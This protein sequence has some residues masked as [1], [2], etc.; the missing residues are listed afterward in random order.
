M[1]E[2]NREEIA[3][4]E[5]LYANNPGG[6][7]F[8]H[9]A[10]AY[11]KA[12]ELDRAR[13]ILEDGITRH[14]EYASA[15]VVLGR[16]LQD[17]GARDEA[18]A[19]FRRV[20]EL[21]PENRVALRSLGDLARDGNQ[22]EEALSYFRQL[23]SLDPTDDQI[24]RT[25][26][27]L[28]AA[29]HAGQTAP[30]G[31]P[32]TKPA[33]DAGAQNAP[34]TPVPA[35]EA[36]APEPRA[37]VT[38][39]PEFAEASAGAVSTRTEELP[40]AGDSAGPAT[41]MPDFA[42]ITPESAIQSVVP[43]A[44]VPTE[45]GD[46]SEFVTP[47]IRLDWDNAE[48]SPA[49]TAPLPGDLAAFVEAANVDAGADAA[50]EAWVPEAG[51]W[52]GEAASEAGSAGDG[53][54][55]QDREPT[56]EELLSSSRGSGRPLA[57]EPER[58]VPQVELQT[59]TLA[60][61]YLSQGFNDRAAEVY[62]SL[63]E[64]NPGD[65]RL[66]RRLAEV[67][68]KLAAAGST[69]AAEDADA[70]DPFWAGGAEAATPEAM[71]YGWEP[72]A[73]EPAGPTIGAYF[74]QLLSWRPSAGHGSVTS[75]AEGAPAAVKAVPEPVAAES[76]ASTFAEA[77]PLPKEGGEPATAFDEM[78]T[79][80]SG[81]GVSAFEEVEAPKDRDALVAQEPA[82]AP[83]TSGLLSQF[84]APLSEVE[85]AFEEWFSGAPPQAPSTPQVPTTAGAQPEAEPATPGQDPV[86]SVPPAEAKP[87]AASASSDEADDDED[88]EMFRSWLQSLKR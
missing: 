67:E 6:R 1:A 81:P 25:I 16:V 58:A 8:T 30:A 18:S 47:D 36:A 71:L 32:D 54:D 39:E 20:L 23:L 86:A 7:V 84:S 15:H 10:E 62:R 59:E 56:F 21:D 82:A 17:Q 34:E 72:E 63:L 29:I 14:A 65:E 79:E 73:E 3:K 9:L 52:Q 26:D 80:E 43:A 46:V 74:G 31:Q 22:L 4:L 64:R 11:R 57:S 77:P 50:A 27:Q 41:E 51:D 44:E 5:A 24:V 33:Q 78:V 2:S 55:A 87:A 53:S 35:P 12:G 61:L 60:E 19:A 68:A 75:A 49:E 83:P 85:A 70:L 13:Q 28:N 37:S 40:G 76:P 45:A 88:L 42:P 48:A 69:A 66:R 38:G